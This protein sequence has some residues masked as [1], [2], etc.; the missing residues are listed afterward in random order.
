ML[1][2]LR[3]QAIDLQ[4]NDAK[5]QVPRSILP[6]R[7]ATPMPSTKQ[8]RQIRA[9]SGLTASPQT[10]SIIRLPSGNGAGMMVCGSAYLQFKLQISQA[11]DAWGFAQGGDAS[12]LIQRITVQQSAILEQ[13]N[14]YNKYVN[15]ILK[16]YCVTPDYNN[17]DAIVSGGA[18]TANNYKAITYAS[19]IGGTTSAN[20]SPKA[21]FAY[22]VGEISVS[23]PIVSGIL[24]N[25]E[26]SY[27]PMELLNQNLELVI[28]WASLND[29][30]YATTTAVTNY[31][32]SDLSVV[33]ETVSVSGEYYNQVRSGLAQ[34][35]LWSIP[36]QSVISSQVADASSV[37]YNM[38]L[39]VSSLDAFFHGKILG[40]NFGST[41]TSKYFT[42]STGSAQST[43]ASTV[44]RRQLLA[45]GDY[46]LQI[47]NNN[48]DAG[49]LRETVRAVCGSIGDTNYGVPFQTAGNWLSEL[50]FRGSHYVD[51][52]NLR[53]WSESSLVNTG[54]P[55]SL[56]TYNKD[57][58]LARAV[59]INYFFAV[60]SFIMVVDASGTCSLIR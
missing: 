55:V 44:S 42:A 47:A 30:F 34:G 14:N 16:A 15:G 48:V 52:Y 59:D 22:N 38:S 19:S 56:L 2:N 57:D 31:A 20:Y 11:S 51:G 33:Y 21:Q 36:F 46:V 1:S 27:I 50:S 28:D 35:K 58:S 40:E 29:A 39:N 17:V 4:Q 18:L 5:G 6:P 10:T 26:A 43:D 13:I 3:D 60:C 12:A 45:D 49:M 9:V 7:L 53:S 37:S 54:R 25:S 8:I 23:I 32:V 24:N 41:I